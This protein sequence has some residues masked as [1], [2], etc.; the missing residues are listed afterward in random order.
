MWRGRRG[1]EKKE[2]WVPFL[3]EF[4]QLEVPVPKRWRDRLNRPLGSTS[5]YKHRWAA[6]ALTPSSPHHAH[7]SIG[8]HPTP[9]SKSPLQGEHLLSQRGLW[10]QVI[11]AEIHEA[12]KVFPTSWICWGQEAW[13]GI[14]L[15]H[16][17]RLPVPSNR[18]WTRPNSP[19]H[20]THTAQ[21]RLLCQRST[22]WWCHQCLPPSSPAAS[23]SWQQLQW[24]HTPSEVLY[25]DSNRVN[26]GSNFKTSLFEHHHR[27]IIDAGS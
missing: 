21:P 14:W 3:G 26:R 18:L 15:L 22:H 5:P 6:L 13:A 4:E 24:P 17:P 19:K 16:I 20:S 9:C 11:R 1:K 12:Y 10:R 8:E 23:C 27:C 2:N 7:Q 25:L